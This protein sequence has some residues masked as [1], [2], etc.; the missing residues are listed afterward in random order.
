MTVRCVSFAFVGAVLLAASAVGSGVSYASPTENIALA[1][2]G[3]KALAAGDA[4]S[5]IKLFDQAIDSRELPVENLANALLNRALA[6]QTKAMHEQALNDYSTALTLDAMAPSLR[7]TALYNRG[8]SHYKLSKHSLAIEDYT[9]ALLLNPTL[10][11]AFYSRG[12]AL[13]D[14]GQLL[15]AITDFNRA[16]KLKHPDPA[17]VHYALA[18]VFLKLRRN[19]DARRELSE[20]L[21]FKPNHADAKAQLDSLG[22]ASLTPAPSEQ[23]KVVALAEAIEPPAALLKSADLAPKQVAKIEKYQD[24]LPQ[25]ES[26]AVVKKQARPIAQVAAKVPDQETI[27]DDIQTGSLP[28]E[29]ETQDEKTESVVTAQIRSGWSVQ[30]S[31][32]ASANAAQSTLQKLKAKHKLSDSLDIKIIK[33]DLGAKGTFYRL[34]LTD[35]GSQ[36]DAKKACSKLKSKGLSCF[37]SKG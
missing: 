30:I 19:D 16:L 22:V 36:G 33:A 21:K 14:N 32:A 31:S 4:N 37:V 24:R 20:T 15:F 25:E 34:R 9:N 3:Y 2:Q 1:S 6:H 10:P 18:E 12:Y 8:L 26:V 5:A 29:A 13:K 23:T 28:P 7:A 27:A 11:Q 35:F 17:S